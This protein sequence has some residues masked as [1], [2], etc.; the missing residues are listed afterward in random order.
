MTNR[1]MVFWLVLVCICCTAS[2]SYSC[3][4]FPIACMDPNNGEG[5]PLVVAVGEP[6]YLTDNGSRDPDG[7]YL[8]NWSWC[9]YDDD[10]EEFDWGYPYT[11]CSF[12]E[13]GL[14]EIRYFVKDDEG[15]W[16]DGWIEPSGP[17][18][19]PGGYDSCWIQVVGAEVE[20]VID[21]DPVADGAEVDVDLVFTP[22]S[23]ADHVTGNPTFTITKAGGGTDYDNP[24]GEGITISIRN[25][26]NPDMAEWQVDNARWFSTQPDHCNETS[27]YAITVNVD[28]D[29]SED[30]IVSDPASLTVGA[31]TNYINGSVTML[32]YHDYWSGD[33]VYS[34]VQVGDHW[35][36]TVSQGT[37]DRDIETDMDIGCAEQSQYY[38]MI[39]HEELFHVAQFSLTPCA[40][41]SCGAVPTVFSDLW[42]IDIIVDAVQANE[43][44]TSSFESDA[45]YQARAAFGLAKYCET[46]RSLNA[47]EGTY[48]EDA[49][50]YCD[51][52]IEAKSHTGAS[53][54]GALECA[55]AG[56][57]EE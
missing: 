3:D 25:P 41:D 31:D 46:S 2:R 21:D 37:F 28:T 6:V 47:I 48:C 53:Y 44:Y 55:H 26:S 32:G 39:L 15:W 12:N 54:I 56:C 13:P 7:G 20:I 4:D 16:S 40:Y 19:N 33:L 23:L 36:C 10:L 35:E 52:E 11:V 30:P 45:R 17:S 9:E 42:D 1:I 57:V 51:M 22:E 5:S 24:A 38:D 29:F 50:A 27:T 43:P 14:H 8:I 18:M 49:E 34:T